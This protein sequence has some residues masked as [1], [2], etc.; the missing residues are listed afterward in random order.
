MF[1]SLQPD[2]TKQ[3][4]VNSGMEEWTPDG[5]NQEVGRHRELWEGP[6][7]FSASCHSSASVFPLLSSLQL[8]PRER[9]CLMHEISE[10][11][12]GLIKGTGRLPKR[13]SGNGKTVDRALQS[14]Q[15]EG[16]P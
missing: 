4:F 5:G 9:G 14:H 8:R 16:L 2:V 6:L 10:L 15:M 1:L 11:K 7:L 13:R 3:E 12:C